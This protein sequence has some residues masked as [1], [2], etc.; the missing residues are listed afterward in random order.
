MSWKIT[1]ELC[2]LA[3]FVVETARVVVAIRA[4]RNR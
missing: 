4:P 1:T 2:F 3:L